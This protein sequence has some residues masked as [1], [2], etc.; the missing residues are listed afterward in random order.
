MAITNSI[1]YW[2]FDQMQPGFMVNVHTTWADRQPPGRLK[3]TAQPSPGVEGRGQFLHL[4]P[5]RK[6]YVH[7]GVESLLEGLRRLAV[8]QQIRGPAG[9]G[10]R[11]RDQAVAFLINLTGEHRILQKEENTRAVQ[12]ASYITQ[13]KLRTSAAFYQHESIL[14]SPVRWCI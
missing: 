14:Q 8:P 9:R 2:V 6:I 10:V 3:P 1:A 7:N 4:W 12:K 5:P 13:K 11:R